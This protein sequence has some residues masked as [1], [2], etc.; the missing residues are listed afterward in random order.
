MESEWDVV[1]R[2]AQDYASRCDEALEEFRKSNLDVGA[3]LERLTPEAGQLRQFHAYAAKFAPVEPAARELLWKFPF[4]LKTAGMWVLGAEEL[5]RWNRLGLE[6][7]DCVEEPDLRLELEMQLH[8]NLGFLYLEKG[9]LTEAAYHYRAA[10]ALARRLDEP[11]RQEQLLGH[12]A[13]AYSLQ[14]EYPRSNELLEES[15]E[16]ARALG[17]RKGQSVALLRLSRN[18][19]SLGQR[20]LGGELLAAAWSAVHQTA[21]HRLASAIAMETGILFASAQAYD[22]AFESYRRALELAER[23]GDRQLRARIEHAIADARFRAGDYEEA[24]RLYE[25]AVPVFLAAGD[26]ISLGRAYNGLGAVQFVSGRPDEALATMR[27]GLL[28][29]GQCRDL[30]GEQNALRNLHLALKMLGRLD[31]AEAYRAAANQAGPAAGSFRRN[32]PLPFGEAPVLTSLPSG[33]GMS[34]SVSSLV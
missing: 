28:L 21:D 4:L 20:E 19:R 5:I 26:Q 27:K 25:G 1:L 31:D 18:Y 22:Q 10:L 8:G 12:L 13:E 34:G 9:G 29:A 15:L 7:A 30:E 2:V 24:R 11:H 16:L 3:V 33:T 32:D 14:G 23:L 6:A 17:D